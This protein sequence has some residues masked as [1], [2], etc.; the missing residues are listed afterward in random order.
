MQA[1]HFAV[2]I[3]S[4]GMLFELGAAVGQNY[5]IKPIRLFAAPPGGSGDFSARLI[6]Q[7]LT[8]ALSQPVIVENRPGVIAID[9]VLKAAPDGYTMILYS[10]S[11]W[12]APLLRDKVSYDAL[13]DFAPV[14]IAVSTPLILVVHPSLPV[15]SV[16]ELIALAKAKPGELNYGS[17]A[18]GGP[19]H[20]ATELFKAMAGV[21]ILRIPYKSGG[22]GLSALMGGEVQLTLES[23]G[24]VAPYIKSGRLRALAVTTQKPSALAPD[25]PTIGASGVPGYE[26]A[27]TIGLFV[28]GRTP[29]A[30]I[31]QLNQET[32]RV[33]QRADVK[34]KL[35]SSGLEVVGG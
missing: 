21:N 17:G 6:S 3:A 22:A 32:V 23:G 8:S 27:S 14:T 28:P 19:T 2:F 1:S 16:K 7:G 29:T 24:A 26:A 10:G 20:L 33:L 5:P 18:A 35:F 11:L 9:T 4:I 30:I 34:E 25:L 13:R 12:L 15:K 31:N